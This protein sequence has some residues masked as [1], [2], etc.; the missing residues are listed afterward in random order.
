LASRRDHPRLIRPPGAQENNL[1][2]KCIRCG[3]CS[4]ACP[5]SAIQ[6]AIAE[7]GLEGLWTPVLIPRIG[8]CDYSCSACGQVCPVQAIPPLSLLEKRQHV[9]GKAYIDRNRC[10][11]WADEQPCGVC[12]EMCP[13]PDK[14]IELEELEVR[15]AEGGL[16]TVQRPHVVRE[17]CIGC[18]I[19]EY[20]CPLSGPAAIRV[21]V[22]SS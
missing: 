20:Q 5:T 8:Y 9:I 3:E 2:A 13:V 19:C 21:H 18:G 10:I 15:D 11:P 1:L 16:L 6:P 7:A 14:A 12:E 17:R 22:P 4:R